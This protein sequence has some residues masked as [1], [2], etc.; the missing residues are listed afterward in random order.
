MP[1]LKSPLTSA[2]PVAG[3]R[4]VRALRTRLG[5]SQ[6][7]LATILNVSVELVQAWEGGRRVPR[8]A[9]L[10]LLEIVRARP[11]LAEGAAAAQGRTI[12][13][14][15]L[16]AAPVERTRS[17]RAGRRATDA[18]LP[19][20][21]LPP[22]SPRSRAAAPL[23]QP[24]G[25]D[26]LELLRRL[27]SHG[28]AFV[29]VGGVAALLHGAPG[30]TDDLDIVYDRSPANLDRLATFLRGIQ[31]TLRG[32]PGTIPFAADPRTLAHTAV[33]AL[34]TNLGPL[35]L[36]QRIAGIGDFHASLANSTIVSLDGRQ[37]PALTLDALIVSKRA[38]GRSK[39]REEVRALEGLRS[40]LR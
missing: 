5:V 32:A 33:L 34:D 26:S 16:P 15:P 8:G 9:A 17:P 22:S 29:T 4:E 27:A 30:R 38:T 37:I 7:T 21:T 2:P 23:A 14:E 13:A 25:G 1:R 35:D 40:G 10:R 19:I 24:A 12:R 20:A 3:A 6:S 18:I 36:R 11:E 31:T 28:V 39:D